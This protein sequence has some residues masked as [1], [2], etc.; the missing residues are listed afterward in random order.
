MYFIKGCGDRQPELV[1]SCAL[2]EI[3]KLSEMR[4]MGYPDQKEKA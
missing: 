1:F 3:L 4:M 2:K